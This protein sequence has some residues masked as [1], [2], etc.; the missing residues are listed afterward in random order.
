VYANVDEVF[1]YSFEIQGHQIRVAS[2][3]LR[4]PW[5]T[6]ECRM[7]DLLRHGANQPRPSDTAVREVH[8]DGTANLEIS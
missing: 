4:A 3:D 2:V 8:E 5:D 7:K 1:D 6:V